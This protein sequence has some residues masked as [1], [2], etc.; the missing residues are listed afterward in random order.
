MAETSNLKQIRVEILNLMRQKDHLW[1][2][3]QLALE[4]EK[5]EFYEKDSDS[6]LMDLLD[7]MK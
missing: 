4:H 5:V 1:E 2:A 3:Y 7:S 6:E